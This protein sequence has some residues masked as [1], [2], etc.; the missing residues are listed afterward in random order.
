MI[1]R[2]ML[3]L[4]FITFSLTIAQTVDRVGWWNFNDT[5]NIVAPV[6]GYGLPL[7]LVGTHQTV[8]GFSASDRAIKIGVGSYYKM[9]HQILPNAGGA[10]VNEYSLQID[11][12]TEDISVWHCFFQTNMQNTD[13]GDCFINTSGYIGVAATGYSAYAVRPNEWYRMIISVKNGTQYK[14]YLDGQLMNNASVQAT[15]SRF[16]L[17]SLL[18]MFADENDED[19][20]IFVSEIGIW[21][22][23]LSNVEVQNLGGFGHLLPTTAGTQ[24]MLVPYLQTPSTNSI[25]VCW[26]DTLSNLTSVEYGNTSALGQVTIGTNEII[27][28]EYRWHT[29]KLTGLQ[30][31]TEYFYKAVS[32]SGSS[33]VYNFRTLPD[34]NYT[35]KIRF[36]LYSDTH[37]NDTTMAVKV[38][39]QSKLIAQQL[40]GNDIHNHINLILH[41]GDLVVSGST[42]TQWTD[43]Y[44]APLSNLSPYL[45]TMTVAGNHEIE[46]QNYYKYMKYDDVNG[47]PAANERFWS[48]K[49]AN[50]VFIGLNS[51]AISSYGTLQKVWLDSYLNTVENDPSVDFVFVMSHHFSITELWGEGITYDGGPGYITNQ[52]YPIL[53]KYS[54]VVQHSYGHTHGYERG[55]FETVDA[56]ARGDFRIVCGGCSGGA[57][58]RW[59]AFVNQDFQAIHLTYDH[60]G[61][62]LIE[63]DVANKTYESKMFSLGNTN[64][65][66]D[67]EMMDTW[68]RKAN[69]QA[70]STPVANAPTVESTKITFNTS[71][72]SGDDSLM[73]VRIQVSLNQNF[74]STVIDTMVH[75]KNVYGVD[76]AFNPI[77]LN[78]GLDLTEL[79]FNTSRFVS[80]NQYHYRVKYRDHNTKWSNWSNVVTFNNVVSVEET[81][82][83]FEFKLDQNYENPFNPSTTIAYTLPADGYTT[84]KVYNAIG[85]LV[86]ELINENQTAGRHQLN[87]NANTL[88]SGIY[89]AEL[90]TDD[91]SVQRIKMILLK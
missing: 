56:D 78:A 46:H 54:K 42:I 1:C 27:S 36:L 86:S 57:T 6:L 22:R 73:T 26:H 68:Y 76:G 17:D 66:R 72:Y 80:G 90:R 13:D 4:F 48:L 24:L 63:I 7:Q 5:T 19:N 21:D 82:L 47:L 33:L 69:Q 11:F 14:Y 87:F 34:S 32:G 91:D 9:K 16:S 3:F 67:N 44:F 39:K 84:L 58:D 10:K 45:P 64:L 20:N 18:L 37:N 79:K 23:A 15:D 75:W 50:T 71:D 70:P 61:Y 25:Y 59:G 51:N 74:G 8:Q 12:K 55:T 30:P 89:F 85:E 31:N 81:S 88:P 35:G 60:Y 41:S 38:I 2:K 83:P 65:I 77:D 40:Y 28:S 53:K 52:I 43:Q 29:V 62:Q 49:I